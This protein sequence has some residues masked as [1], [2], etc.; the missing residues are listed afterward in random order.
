V[1]AGALNMLGLDIEKTMKEGEVTL[2][3]KGF[4]EIVLFTVSDF[5]NYLW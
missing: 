5:E 3:Q 2:C 4:H 1:K